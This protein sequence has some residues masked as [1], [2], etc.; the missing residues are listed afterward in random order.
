MYK[1]FPCLFL[2]VV[3]SVFGGSQMDLPAPYNSIELLPFHSHSFYRNDKQIEALL[4]SNDIKTIIEV[5]SWLG[6][7]TRHMASLLPPGGKVYAVDHWKGSAE[8]QPGQT[9]W[10][11]QVA[12][13]YEQFLSN[14]IHAGL[15][16]KIIPIKMDSSDAAVQLKTV[17]VPDLIYIDASH[18]YESV[19]ADLNRWYPYVKGHGIFCGDDWNLPGVVQAVTEF[20]GI[21]GLEI[22]ASGAFWLLEE[23]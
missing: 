17:V 16:D 22:H 7:S 9:Y 20:A 13:L 11:A 8:N 6:D 18:D 3:S 12:Y 14:V 5:G 21:N 4:R 19:L 10:I 15:T 23:K 2:L 1:L